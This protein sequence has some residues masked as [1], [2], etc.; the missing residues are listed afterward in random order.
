MCQVDLSGD[1]RNSRICLDP[2]YFGGLG[3]DGI[4]LSLVAVGLEISDDDVTDRKL[5]GRGTNQSDRFRFEL[6]IQHLF[7]LLQ[8]LDKCFDVGSGL[9][10]GDTA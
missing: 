7:S 4:D 2:A 8:L 9:F 3:V 5:F 6:G 1:I 10:V